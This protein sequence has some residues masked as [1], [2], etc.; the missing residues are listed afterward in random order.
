MK[1][2]CGFW[3]SSNTKVELTFFFFSPSLCFLWEG[4]W[5]DSTNMKVSMC[6]VKI[7]LVWHWPNESNTSPGNKKVCPLNA[8]QSKKPRSFGGTLYEPWSVEWTQ[9]LCVGYVRL[10]STQ[11]G[12]ELYT[13][14][15]LH[16]LCGHDQS[17]KGFREGGVRDD[18]GRRGERQTGWVN[19]SRRG[20]YLMLYERLTLFLFNIA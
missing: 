13:L 3:G 4:H 9:D 12:L 7:A 8:D 18:G 10:T 5:S 6:E 2:P 16:D 14:G 15:R 1:F 20:N 19:M 17:F 11:R